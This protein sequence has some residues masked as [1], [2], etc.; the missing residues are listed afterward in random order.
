MVWGGMITGAAGGGDQARV[1]E[2]CIGRDDA[3]N[4]R[5]GR[6]ERQVCTVEALRVNKQV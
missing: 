3:P 4:R 5:Q 6:Q 1:D 2:D